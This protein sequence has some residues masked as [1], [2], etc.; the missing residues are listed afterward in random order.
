ML[1]R[2]VAWKVNNKINGF[3]IGETLFETHV[4]LPWSF[5]LKK[6]RPGSMCPEI[7]VMKHLHKILIISLG[8]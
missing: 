7:Q 6:L 1:M 5:L 2:T 3:L 8:I 4:S